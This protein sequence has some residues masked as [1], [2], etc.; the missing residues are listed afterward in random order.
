MEYGAYDNLVQELRCTD[1]ASFKNLVR[2]DPDMF[3]G[4]LGRIEDR[5]RKED[6]FWRP[7]LRPGLKLAV[8][9]RYY[10]SGDSYHSLQYLF[11]VPANS[12]CVFIPEVSDAIVEEYANEVMTCPSTPQGWKKIAE[13]FFE[14]WNFPHV[15]GAIDGK[16]IAIRKPANSGSLYINYKKFFSIVLMGVVDA[17]YR[18]IWVEVGA[19]GSAS[20]A[21]IFQSCEFRTKLDTGEHNL[22]QPE[23]ITGCKKNLPYFLVG[24]DAFPMREWLMKPFTNRNQPKDERIFNYRL[25]RARRIVENAFGILSQRFQ[26]MLSTMRMQPERV[27]SIVLACCCLH[28]LFRMQTPILRT[29]A[30][31]QEDANHN[32]IPGE[33]REVGALLDGVTQDGGNYQLKAAKVQRNYLKR[34]FNNPIGQVPWQD[35]MVA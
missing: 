30:V 24:D 12:I 8:T 5:I 10:A 31:D 20:D 29:G 17:N 25:S 35:R 4:I 16:H 9:V 6:T 28:N 19:N 23:P 7:A 22:P 33:W 21:Q 3:Y 34:Y 18:F 2:M 1:V 27:E 15:I 26:C 14:R 13:E 11:R 32:I